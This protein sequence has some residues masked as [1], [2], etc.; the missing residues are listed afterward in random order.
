MDERKCSDVKQK[1]LACWL[2][3]LILVA[4]V[5]CGAAAA[6]LVPCIGQ[7]AVLKELGD[8]WLFWPCLVFFWLT[9]IPVIWCL[10]L[11][12]RIAGEIGRDNSFCA[13][14]ALRLRTV[15]RLAIADTLAYLLGAV[16]L[17][18]LGALQLPGLLVFLAVMILGS[19]LAVGM[20]ALSHLIAKAADLKADSDLTI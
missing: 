16:S 11:A 20:A 17:T 19:A 9:L 14:N 4:F 7:E 15:S 10:I 18:A 1:E 2:K 5:C 6:W 8:A 3:F 12:W 13:E